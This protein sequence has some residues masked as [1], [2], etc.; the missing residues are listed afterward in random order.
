MTAYEKA[1]SSVYSREG[2]EEAPELQ[3]QEHRLLWRQWIRWAQQ[4][5][6]EKGD[7]DR[8]EIRMQLNISTV[9]VWEKPL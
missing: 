7:P 8:R 6:P 1:S 5:G 4:Q 3:E 9:T 2:L